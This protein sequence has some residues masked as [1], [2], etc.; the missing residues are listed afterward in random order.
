MNDLMQRIGMHYHKHRECLMEICPMLI[1][2]YE[3]YQL[4]KYLEPLIVSPII[5]YP[6]P[7]QKLLCHGVTLY[8]V[9]DDFKNE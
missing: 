4:V 9:G 7:G 5:K 1:T 2:E 6:S 8:V 3:A